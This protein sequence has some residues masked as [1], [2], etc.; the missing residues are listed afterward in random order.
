MKISL[1]GYRASGK[2]TLGRELSRRLGWP[3]LDIDR[4]LEARFPDETLTELWLRIGDP[5]F[6]DIEA[7][8]V[9]EMCAGDKRV[10]SFGAGT[11]GRPEN[12]G[13][14][15]RDALV[16]YLEMS[17]E[18]LW[19]R[20][21]ADPMNASTRPNLAGGGFQEVVEMLARR[22]P[23]YR[24]CAG[25]LVDAS[26]PTERL[27]GIVIAELETRRQPRPNAADQFQR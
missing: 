12:R 2:S 14:A 6:R 17:A 22:D 24:E 20:M 8:V 9:A 18:G 26:L 11:L 5:R 13:H 25:L 23:V 1:I 10:I 7:E 16:V 21:Q 15:C 19:Q 4:G 3:L 27:A